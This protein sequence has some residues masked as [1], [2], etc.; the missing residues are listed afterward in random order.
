MD[1]SF[2]QALRVRAGR[3]STPRALL[4]SSLL[5]IPCTCED[6]VVTQLRGGDKLAS[7]EDLE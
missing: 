4:V 2:A 1:S 7:E 6:L 3:L 5:K